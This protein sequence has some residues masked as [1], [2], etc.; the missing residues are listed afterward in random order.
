MGTNI[1]PAPGPLHLLVWLPRTSFLSCVV[2]CMGEGVGSVAMERYKNTSSLD[3]GAYS[4]VKKFQS[5]QPDLCH[6]LVRSGLLFIVF[7]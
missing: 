7:I 1:V 4:L 2:T 5:A 6:I 3:L